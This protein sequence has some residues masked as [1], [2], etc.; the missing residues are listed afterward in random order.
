M[1]A[2]S[3]HSARVTRLLVNKEDRKLAGLLSLGSPDS[4]NCRDGNEV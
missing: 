3:A 1:I 4:V 2:T